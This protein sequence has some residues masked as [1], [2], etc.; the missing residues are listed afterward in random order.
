[1]KK[2]IFI[3]PFIIITIIYL[4]HESTV[5]QIGDLSPKITSKLVENTKIISSTLGEEFPIKNIQE[6]DDYNIQLFA[7]LHL[8]QSF[9]KIITKEEM[10]DISYKYL[11]INNTNYQDI[12]CPLDNIEV[13][14]YDEKNKLFNYVDKH[15]HG[16]V[17]AKLNNKIYLLDSYKEDDK[18]IIEVNIL[19]GEL[20]TG[21]QGDATKYYLTASNSIE[22]K[23]KLF[24]ITEKENLESNYQKLKNNLPVY[25]V[26]F[27][28]KENNYLFESIIEK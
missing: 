27:K 8:N 12:I 24:E 1:M 26:S 28:K 14:K 13:Y 11:N 17:F 7:F 3:I 4:N 19:F 2:L 21:Y 16:E 18:Y 9:T 6:V 5:I 22:R 10:D 23:D 20:N 15:D 25:K